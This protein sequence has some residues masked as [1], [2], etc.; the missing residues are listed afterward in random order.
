MKLDHL[1]I[2]KT[3]LCHIYEPSWRRFGL[4]LLRTAFVASKQ[5][6]PG[7]SPRKSRPLETNAWF[8][9]VP[10]YNTAK[11]NI[12]PG[13]RPACLQACRPDILESEY[14]MCYKADR[15]NERTDDSLSPVVIRLFS[16]CLVLRNMLASAYL[17]RLTCSSGRPRYWR[18]IERVDI[19]GYKKVSLNFRSQYVGRLFLVLYTVTYSLI[20]VNCKK[21]QQAGRYWKCGISSSAETGWVGSS[22]SCIGWQKRRSPGN[23]V[24]QNFIQKKQNRSGE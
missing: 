13:G 21:S 5:Q 6:T 3:Y 18:R 11:L 19:L 2:L 10:K 24:L 9:A 1:R 22:S 20:R 8:S 17:A 4:W 23:I 7:N 14:F 12:A 16:V 15:S